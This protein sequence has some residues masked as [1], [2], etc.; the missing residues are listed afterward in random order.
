[1]LNS[2]ID[3]ALEKPSTSIPILEEGSGIGQKKGH[4]LYVIGSNCM[5][6]FPGSAVE[7]SGIRTFGYEVTLHF[8]DEKTKDAF[9]KGPNIGNNAITIRRTAENMMQDTLQVENQ[10]DINGYY[11]AP[12]DPVLAETINEGTYGDIGIVQEELG[13]ILQSTF[14]NSGITSVTIDNLTSR[15]GFCPAPFDPSFADNMTAPPPTVTAGNGLRPQQHK[16]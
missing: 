4:T 15:E 13:A 11:G 5:E 1:M 14:P 9:N 10:R 12:D 3:T 6:Y 7:S 16:R 8:A 2:E